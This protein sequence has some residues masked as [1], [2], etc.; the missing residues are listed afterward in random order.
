MV[1]SSAI[2]LCFFL[3]LFFL[4]YYLIVPT[5]RNNF[6]VAASIFFYWW[7]APLFVFVILGTTITDFFLVRAM[8]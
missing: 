6:I 7:G 4:L 1:F 8:W 2:F 5:Y 3:P